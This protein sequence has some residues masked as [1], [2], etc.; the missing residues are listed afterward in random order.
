[1]S[2]TL[3]PTAAESTHEAVL[4]DLGRGSLRRFA[5]DKV[6]VAGLV[7][8]VGVI[9]VAVAAPLLAPY[10][11]NVQNLLVINAHPS[12]AHW[13]GT[14][15]LGR[16]MLSRLIWGARPAMRAA[17][18]IVGG[19]LVVALP[20]A[21]V[22]GFVRGKV[23]TVIMRA[24]DALFSFPPL[25][26]ALTVA[27]LL[28]PNLND[29][30]IAIS[31]VFVPSFVR[32]IRGEV[33]AVREENYVEAA[34]A[35][36]VPPVRL[37]RTHILPNVASPLIVQ[38]A[39]ALGYSVLISAGLSY[40]GVG[41]Q[42][43]T[44]DW[45]SM[46]YEAYGHIF[47]SPLVLV[48]PGVAILLTV[49]AFNL[50]ADGLRD[51]MGRE[52][53][54]AGSEGRRFGRRRARP[55]PASPDLPTTTAAAAVSDGAGGRPGELLTVEHLRVEFATP[56]GWTA[57]VEDVGFG[58][59][60]GQ[61]LGL[62]GESGSGKT[63]SALGIMG[64]LPRRD[65]RVA[66]GAVL[67]EG[68][69]LTEMSPKAMRHVRGNEIAM[70]FQ[71]PMT[72]LNPA[73][74]VGNQIAEQVRAHRK[75]SRSQAWAQALDM[76]DQ[77]GIPDPRRRA[78]D[79]PHAF[80][81][82]MRQ[83]VMIAMALS[84]EP[85]LLIA[86]EPTTALDVT[87]QAQI[88]ELLKALQRDR[89]MAMIFVTHDLGVIADIA[90]EVVVMYAGQVVE[91]APVDRLFDRP[92]HPYGEALLASMPQL[93]PPGGALHV[94]P[95]RVPRPDEE[96]A[97]CRFGPRC[98]YVT[99]RCR[100]APVA[101]E[102]VDRSGE[103]A[104]CIRQ[105]ELTL[106]GVAS[107]RRE[108]E[109]ASRRGAE[110]GETL[111]EVRALKVAF[112]VRSGALKRVTGAVQAVQ[113]VGLEVPAGRTLGLV[114]ESGSGKSTLARLILRLMEPSGGTIVFAG[115][116][117]SRLG[118][119]ELRE[120]RRSL[121]IVF[122][123]PYSSLDPRMRVADIVGEPLEIYDG[124]KGRAR[125]ERVTELLDQVGLGSYALARRPHEFSGGQ[126]QRIAIARAL[127]SGPRLL[128]CDEPVSALDVSTQSQVINLLTD[129]KERLG[130]AV[131]FIAHDLSVVRHMSDRI[132]V[133][134]LGRIV[135]EGPADEVYLRPRHPYTQALLSAIPVPEVHR[136]DEGR[137][138]VLTGEVANPL[139]PPTGCSFHPRCPYAMDICRSVE[140]EAVT[141]DSGAT[142]RCHLHTSGPTLRGEP[143][144]ALDPAASTPLT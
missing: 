71:E 1:V 39:L 140:P 80:S 73:F 67:F 38:V 143:V 30:S 48:F 120:L 25:I 109:E 65:C 63:V 94:I 93:A 14:D 23:D 130:L 68:N 36:G 34:R 91:R 24:M 126:R 110:A 134:Y 35:T 42:P 61:T 55:E 138:I 112:P 4:P 100:W 22:A 16:D 144:T 59:M 18:Q 32:L 69:D 41:V 113:E 132:A 108:S 28:G 117:L 114:G 46:L 70:I 101:L 131:I 43:P 17:F 7:W 104:R 51:A 139:D 20:L 13:L 3:P 49:L 12:A 44:A 102:P 31:I 72:S 97:G 81:G 15:D 78:R 86:D 84:C 60:P 98:S 136:A 56:T 95:G 103:L 107:L 137:R 105:D 19:A 141:F 37:V 74:T 57:V 77:V 85:K 64:L 125:D 6:P 27:A 83:R 123:D 26:L 79:Y 75:V 99:D 92:R 50:V 45:G 54:G 124:V 47:A 121:Q 33:I 66:E 2:T 89:H 142:V 53:F 128:V 8:I 90:D 52:R 21:L 58:V 106:S 87:T 11:P 29:A 96:I 5:A 88:L 135:E 119:H 115:H 118:R 127:A 133:M 116:D 9:F 82:G 122:Q 40:L 10:A 129:L 111:L 76:L 62:V